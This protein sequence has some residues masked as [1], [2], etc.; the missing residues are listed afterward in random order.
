MIT[1]RKLRTEYEL[2]DGNYRMIVIKHE[3]GRVTLQ[4]PCGNRDFHFHTSKPEVI[5]AMAK[6]MLKAIED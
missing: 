5:K 2:T 3:D 6:L 4:K 1:K